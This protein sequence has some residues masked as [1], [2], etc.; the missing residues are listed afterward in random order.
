MKLSR[1]KD[2]LQL[3][4]VI[5]GLAFAVGGNNTT[6]PEPTCH[7]P[8]CHTP[9]GPFDGGWCDIILLSLGL[10]AIVGGVIMWQFV[11]R[12]YALNKMLKKGIITKDEYEKL[13]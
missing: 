2:W 5:P 13:K 1:I 8:A 9:S 10:V 4:I 11:R 6:E 7:A 12:R 3:N